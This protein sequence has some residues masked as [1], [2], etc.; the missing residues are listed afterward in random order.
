MLTVVC[1][2]CKKQFYYKNIWSEWVFRLE[3]GYTL[4]MKVYYVNF[5]NF[6][7]VKWFFYLISLD[8]LWIGN[9]GLPYFEIIYVSIQHLVIYKKKSY[10]LRFVR[11]IAPYSYTERPEGHFKTSILFNRLIPL[12]FPYTFNYTQIEK[13]LFVTGI[14]GNWYEFVF[15]QLQR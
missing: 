10:S 4:P 12:I 1:R 13:K 3:W 14:W 5:L 8:V 7:K 11:G 15:S 6:N 9:T 2:A